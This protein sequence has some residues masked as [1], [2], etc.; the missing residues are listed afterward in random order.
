MTKIFKYP[1]KIQQKQEIS[2]PIGVV[3][4]HVGLDPTGEPCIWCVVE[5]GRPTID[6]SIIIIG[7]GHEMPSEIKVHIGS[8]VQGPYVWHVFQG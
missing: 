5:I 7:T 4:I 1:I 2:V 3:P 8:F 6:M